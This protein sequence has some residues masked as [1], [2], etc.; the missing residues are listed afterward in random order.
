MMRTISMAWLFT[1][2][3]GLA[4]AGCG[5]DGRPPI[6]DTGVVGDGGTCPSGQTNCSGVCVDTRYDPANC[7]GCGMDCGGDLCNMGTCSGGCGVGTVECGGRCV[8]TQVD[9]MNC[10]DCGIACMTGEVCGA[11]ACTTECPTGT[12]DCSGSCV[13]TAANVSHCGGCGMACD[14]GL[15]CFD[16]ACGM[17]PTVDTDGDTISDFDEQSSIPRDTDGDGTPDYMDDDSDGD[18]ITDADEAGDAEVMTPP[19][20]TDGDGTP[21]FQDLDA[22]NDG[23]DDADEITLGTDPTDTDSDGD[24]ES[25]G[26]E[27][28]GGTDPTDPMDN[29]ASRGDFTF[30]LVPGGM[31]RT[32]TLEFDPQIRK[33]DVLFL[34]DTTGSMGGTISGL[35][36]FLS[37]IVTDVRSAI[38]DT[39][40]GV[41]RFD[42][43]P[44]SPYGSTTTDVPFGLIQRVT[45][46]MTDITSGVTGL[47]LHSGADGPESQIEAMFQAATGDG[48]RSPGGT[49]WTAPFDPAAGFDA[50]R[51]HGMIGGAGYR[52]DALPIV[53]VATD[54]TFHRKWGDNSTAGDNF[55]WCGDTATDSCDNYAMTSFGTAA[56]QQPKTQAETLTALNAIGAKVI[57]LAVDNGATTSDE[58]HE[59]SAF[60]V[61]TGAYKT[62]TAGMCN[63]GISGAMRAAE[64][65]DPDGTGPLT[66]TS[67]CPFVFSTNS[68]GGGGV[69]TSITSAIT[70]LTSF[71]SFTTLHT[72]SRDDPATAAVDES[73]FFV[74]GIPVSWDTATCTPAPSLVDRLDGTGATGMDGVVDSF[75]DVVPG[76]LVTFQIVAEN[77]GFVPATCGD[78]LFNMRVIVIGDDVVEADSREVI[79]RVP[80]D[81]T[82]CTTP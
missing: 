22:D 15:A 27:V 60:A 77:D 14:P 61:R 47:T 4:L 64:M 8:D 32:D 76:C 70:D 3:V 29:L 67:V 46:N 10:G 43:M 18:G 50:S 12:T 13:D 5:D 58:R 16:G 35:R 54:I 23:V 48:F 24:G 33:A 74:R 45:T 34:I 19:V 56:D 52:M 49:A 69:A 65:W 72:E 17:R 80:G 44:T 42:D 11:G 25:D 1:A 2:M 71:V 41:A 68:S 9:P 38:P 30:D 51:G 7:G 81:R 21:D 31:A 39:A 59:L 63:T 78:Q 73:Q 79:V 82:L 36:T 20:D 6:G 55:T 62:P 28:A 53:I 66:A 26:V 57:G 40:F 37:S 75:T